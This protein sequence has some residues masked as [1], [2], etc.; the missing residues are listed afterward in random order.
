MI[1]AIRYWL[2]RQKIS[3]GLIKPGQFRVRY[4]DDVWSVRTTYDV[5]RT[6]AQVFGGTVHW[7]RYDD[8][9]QQSEKEQSNG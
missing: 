7:V 8:P 5:A 2:D 3:P 6:Y 9:A 1:R 4:N